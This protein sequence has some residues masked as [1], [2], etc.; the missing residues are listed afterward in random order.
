[1]LFYCKVEGGGII[2]NSLNHPSLLPLLPLAPPVAPYI[3][4]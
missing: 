1:M 2:C 4:P 3:A